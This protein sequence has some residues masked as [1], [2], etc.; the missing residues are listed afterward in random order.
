MGDKG[1]GRAVILD[2][3][4]KKVPAQDLIVSTGSIR[5]VEEA[6]AVDE[7]DLGTSIEPHRT[8]DEAEDV[9]MVDGDALDPGADMGVDV[10]PKR[11]RTASPSPAPKKRRRSGGAKP[12]T[13]EENDSDTP[14]RPL[15]TR[16]RIHS[17]VEVPTPR[18]DH[19][20][21]RKDDTPASTKLKKST[22]HKLVA[23]ETVVSAKKS[24]PVKAK[25]SARESIPTVEEEGE[26][27]EEPVSAK[28]SHRKKSHKRERDESESDEEHERLGKPTPGPSKPKAT[29]TTRATQRPLQESPSPSVRQDDAPSR[30]RR[31]AA[32]RADEKLKDIM[33]DVINF[34][35]EM[36]R[37]SVISEW[38]KTE[39][40]QERTD[41][42]TKEKEKSKENTRDKMKETGKKRRSDVRYSSSGS[43]FSPNADLPR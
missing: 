35:K 21:S 39:K 11:E 15:P 26:E 36:K 7:N 13:A 20:S 23:S 28:R 30:G 2:D 3:A 5:E 24:T 43:I 8:K 31:S 18:P 19:T 6:I 29:Q 12:S 33:P 27:E 17:P 32:Q 22:S 40:E 42:K 41:K 4:E 9:E 38:E 25:A 16:R 37:G 34:Q 10:P 1:I 14:R